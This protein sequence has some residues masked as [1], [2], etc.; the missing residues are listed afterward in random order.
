MPGM[1]KLYV[2]GFEIHQSILVSMLIYYETMDRGTNKIICSA[3]S[4]D[5]KIVIKAI[6]SII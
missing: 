4:Y 2:S 5:L 1:W 3:S 6:V